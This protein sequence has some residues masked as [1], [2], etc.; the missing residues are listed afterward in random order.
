MDQMF[1]TRGLW[2][3]WG[4]G[5]FLCRQDNEGRVVTLVMHSEPPLPTHRSRSQHW[6]HVFLQ[7]CHCQDYEMC[8]DKVLFISFSASE[9]DNV[10][11]SGV[12]LSSRRHKN[13]YKK[14][15]GITASNKRELTW[16]SHDPDYVSSP[17]WVYLLPVYYQC[18]LT[19]QFAPGSSFLGSLL[20]FSACFVHRHKSAPVVEWNMGSVVNVIQWHKSSSASPGLVCSCLCCWKTYS[21]FF[22]T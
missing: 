4:S 22:W 20:S 10:E 15:T 19:F 17:F 12:L 7:Y 18:W 13:I 1:T 11:T 6:V 16:G 2:D 5:A 8:A 21:C 9:G 14:C 3:I